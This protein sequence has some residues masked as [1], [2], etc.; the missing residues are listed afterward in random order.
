MRNRYISLAITDSYN[1]REF[2]TKHLYKYKSRLTKGLETKVMSGGK[3]VGGLQEKLALW[4]L[5]MNVVR[6]HVKRLA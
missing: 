2:H 6:F 3:I 1:L 5:F 4:R